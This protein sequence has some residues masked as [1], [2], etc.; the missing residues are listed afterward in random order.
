MIFIFPLI[1]YYVTSFFSLFIC[2]VIFL[3]FNFFLR[4]DDVHI[5]LII[6]S[7]YFLFINDDLQL[8]KILVITF[9]YW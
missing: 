6:F 7:W 8:D 3:S 2:F 5:L 1:F 4:S 9:D